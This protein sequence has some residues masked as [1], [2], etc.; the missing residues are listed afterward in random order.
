MWEEQV[1]P[2]HSW[3]KVCFFS[4]V[5]ELVGLTTMVAEVELSTELSFGTSKAGAVGGPDPSFLFLPSVFHHW[6][7]TQPFPCERV[8]Q[9]G[10]TCAQLLHT[11]QCQG[12]SRVKHIEEPMLEEMGLPT[13]DRNDLFLVAVHELGHALGLEH[14][15]DPSAIMAPFYQYMETHNFKLPQDDLQGIQKIYDKKKLFFS[16]QSVKSQQAAFLENV[17]FPAPGNFLPASPVE[18]AAG[19]VP[20]VDLALVLESHMITSC[21]RQELSTA[22]PLHVNKPEPRCPCVWGLFPNPQPFLCMSHCTKPCL[23]ELSNLCQT[24]SWPAALGEVLLLHTTER[25]C[26]VSGCQQEQ[27]QHMWRSSCIQGWASVHLQL[28]CSTLAPTHDTETAPVTAASILPTGPPIEPLEPTRPLPTL[29]VRRI[30]STSE[31]KHE[32]QPRPPSPPLGDRPALPGSKPNI[33]DGN[34]NTVALFRGEMFVFKDRWFWRLRNNRVQEGYPMQIEQFWKG[35][36][37][38]IDAAYERSDGKFVFFKGDKYWVFKEVTAEPGY[39]HSLVELGSCLPREGI[40]TALRWEPVGKT[41]FFKGDRYWRYNEDKRATDPGYPKPI[42]VWRGIPQAPQGAFISKEGFYTYFYK[43]KE[44]WKFD[45]QRLSV[46]PGYPRSIL[47]DWMG[48][49][50]KD[51]ERSKD[52]RLPHDDVD[53]MV[54]INDMPSTVNAIAVVIPCILSLCILVLVYT[55]FQFKNKEVQQNVVYYKRPVQEWRS[56]QGTTEHSKRYWNA[57]QKLKKHQTRHLA[58]S[59]PR[60][61]QAEDKMLSMTE[62]SVLVVSSPQKAHQSLTTIPAA[63]TSLPRFTVPACWDTAATPVMMHIHGLFQL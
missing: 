60:L 32:R 15:N 4:T 57:E 52:R 27:Q 18:V 25:S 11:W 44:Y 47:K 61:G 7:P 36:P 29:P 3:E 19:S 50:Q 26:G 23:Q 34:F 49:N 42:T 12:F 40:D 1:F 24:S 43:G 59:S 53:I 35:L 58:T 51:V 46:E 8:G 21:R 10:D 41:Y 33:C 16:T 37:A 30:H 54:T 13:W 56:A 6:D 20:W 2:K 48:C 62:S 39:P 63:I 55:I 14:S 17:E 22:V 38:K 45:N 5:E 9:D 31:R 28:G